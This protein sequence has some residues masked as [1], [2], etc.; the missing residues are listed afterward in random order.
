MMCVI[1]SRTYRILRKTKF[2]KFSQLERV[3]LILILYIYIY[4]HTQETI[5]NYLTNL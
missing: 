1:S 5:L 3:H 4:T 2:S